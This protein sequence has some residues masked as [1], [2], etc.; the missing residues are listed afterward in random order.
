MNRRH[1]LILV[2]PAYQPRLAGIAR[3]ARQHDW[4]LTILD[5]IARQPKGWKGDGVLV[6]LRDNPETVAFVKSLRRHKIPVV[7][8]TFNHPEMRLPRVSGDH[9]LMGKLARLHFDER[10]FR[11]FAWF[12]TNWLNIHRL[13]YEGFRLPTAKSSSLAQS[14]PRWVLSEEAPMNR[15]DDFTW[16]NHWL[17][18][19][20]K[21][22]PKPLALLAYDD[23]DAARALGACITAGLSV[24]EDVSVLGIGGDRLIC[25]NQPVPI[26]SIEHD[27]GRTGYEGA[28]L[29]DHLMNG[30]EPPRKPILIPPRGITIRASTDVI[31]ATSPIVRKSLEYIRLNIGTSFGLSQIATNAGVSRTTVAQLF[32]QELGRSVGAEIMRQRLDIAKRLLANDALSIAEVAYRTGFCNPAYFTN[33]FRRTTGLTPKAWRRNQSPQIPQSGDINPRPWAR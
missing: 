10:N 16:F 30:A 20:L 4:Q 14:P 2:T 11:N 7:D 22:A 1:V 8:L 12:S 15:L 6:T 26:S 13:R 9:F 33:T 19:K 28:E 31:A 18:E 3:Y 25:E 5:R 32:E 27:Q 21:S 23:V 17:G 24:P 29:L